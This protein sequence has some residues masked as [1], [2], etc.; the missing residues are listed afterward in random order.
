[1]VRTGR[2]P[3]RLWCG[4]RGEN[5][6]RPPQSTRC[7]SGWRA[8]KNTTGTSRRWRAPRLTC[9]PASSWAARP[10]RRGEDD[11][12]PRDRGRVSLDGGSVQHSSAH[13]GAARPRPEEIGVVPQELAI[14]PKLTAREN[15][16]V[17][18][19]LYGVPGRTLETRVEWA[20]EW[21]DLK[22]R[23]D[24][25]SMRFSGG[26]SAAS[27]S[28]AACCTS[29]RSSCSTSRPSAWIRRAASASTRCSPTL[30][31]PASPS[32]SP[33]TISRRPSALR[34][35]RD[36]RPR[37]DRRGQ[38]AP[39][40]AGQRR[41]S[42]RARAIAPARST[43]RGRRAVASRPAR[44]GR[45]S[46]GRSMRRCP[47]WAAAACA[48]LIDTIARGGSRHRRRHSWPAAS[49]QDVFIALTGRELR[50]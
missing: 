46:P 36:H 9:G 21:S 11:R 4:G 16:E 10:Q 14:Y 22:D 7:R 19:R 50:E 15:L 8:R 31:A 20:L 6:W 34:A 43:R 41:R 39:R 45:R 49:L 38:A 47:T 27:T 24:E 13:A 26:M 1:M 23:R 48:T 29:R 42:A 5:E 2:R 37:H 18:G 12:D 17:F 33:R 44:T 25:P 30:Q 40:R 32:C 28:R 3:P 35:H